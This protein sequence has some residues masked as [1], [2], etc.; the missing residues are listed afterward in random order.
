MFISKSNTPSNWPADDQVEIL[1]S[2]NLSLV[3]VQDNFDNKLHCI[4]FIL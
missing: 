1:L 2:S 4:I 3:I